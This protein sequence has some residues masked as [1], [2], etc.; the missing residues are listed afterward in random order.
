[1]TSRRPK[2]KLIACTLCSHLTWSGG[3]DCEPL[4]LGDIDLLPCTTCGHPA[5]YSHGLD[6]YLHLD[7]RRDNAPCWLANVRGD[8]DED[9]ERANC[10]VLA[11]PRHRRLGAA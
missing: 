6:R 3:H 1:M 2:P 8:I 11:R 4:P 7:S 9:I 5:I 10:L